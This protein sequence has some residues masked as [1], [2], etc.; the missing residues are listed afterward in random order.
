MKRRPTPARTS[1]TVAILGMLAAVPAVVAQTGAA[2]AQSVV[3]TQDYTIGNGPVSGPT[4]VAQPN[5]AG[6]TSNYTVGFTTP[7]ALS[8]TT[9]TITLSDPAN[10]TIF[11]AAQNDYFVI[12]NTA[13]SGPQPVSSV[14]LGS[15]NHSATLVLGSA[16]PAGHSVSIYV[17]GATNPANAGTYSLNL[18]TSG[19]PAVASTP[20]YQIGSSSSTPAFS[21]VATPAAAGGSA[22]YTIGSFKAAETIAAGGV[23]A[24]TSYATSG[25]DNVAFPTDAAAYK[26][27]DLTTQASFAPGAVTIATAGNGRTGEAVLLQLPSAIA[28][29]DELSVTVNGV[30]NPT[31]TQTDTITAA[32]PNTAPVSTGSLQV[33]T[34]VT[35]PTISI[36]QS[37]SGSSG[38]EYIVGFTAATA[39]PSGGTVTLTAPG[40]TSFADAHV[41]VVDTTNA[42]ASASV[43]GSSVRLT[44]SGT[45][46]TF[47]ELSFTLPAGITAGDT[48]YVEVGGV[49]NPPAGTYGG[50]A[51]NFTIATSGDVI[52]VNVPSYEVTATAAP[53]MASVLLSSTAPSAQAQYTIGDLQANVA[54][55][56]ATGT[57]E[58]K[59]PS[60]TVFPAAV[61]DYTVV[62]LTKSAG[63]AQV[64]GVVGGGTNDVTMTLGGSVGAGD[65]IDVVANGVTNPGPGTYNISVLGDVTAAV[66]PAGSLGS[67]TPQVGAGYWLAT[68]A[69]PVFGAGAAKAMGS[70]ATT[71][72]SGP[73][74]GIAGTP[75]GQGYW[76][77]TANGTVAAF[78]DAKS[79]G[80]LPADKVVASDI[81][82]VAPTS[83]GQGYWLVGRDGGMF[84]FG[85]AK[86]HGSVPGLKLH[87]SNIVGMVASPDGGGYLVVGSDGGVFTF[88]TAR[89]H[90]SLPGIHKHVKDIRAILPSSTGGGYVLVGSDGGAFVF[91]TGAH[92]VGSL[93]GRNIKVDDIVGLAL[94]PDDGGYYMA[95]SNGAVYAFGDAASLPAPSGLGKNLPVVAIAG[96]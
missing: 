89:F 80:D 1:A 87:V 78:G 93:P 19:N 32:A 3:T 49:A 15:G 70:V 16:I 48:V 61:T 92:F 90:G 24:I 5:T 75:D 54:L 6:A 8:A 47:N 2:T 23:L 86:F 51:G 25:T 85:D 34:S 52:P 62:D 82:A 65:Y 30:H 21:A 95:G 79:Y 77:V 22:T 69:G 14:Q 9:G 10:A 37:G 39:L 94:T 91:G 67:P 66:P 53:Q 72:T 56:G 18:S 28:A 29:G 13:A 38:V 4:A 11:P 46:A 55:T 88:G 41:T 58:L 59:A 84:A 43:A 12:D 31:S 83:D 45:S 71:K 60:G 20:T 7:T 44:Q 40:G 17:V 42:A 73:V 26:V 35:N 64:T 68:K 57:L 50:T 33:G 76:E 27:T 96:T 74:V 36:S 63:S 81:V